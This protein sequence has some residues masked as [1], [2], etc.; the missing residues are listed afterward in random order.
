MHSQGRTFP[1]TPQNA[2]HTS[3]PAPDPDP[4]DQF[5]RLP[6]RRLGATHCSRAR[7]EDARNSAAACRRV[8]RGF[9]FS[10]S[11]AFTWRSHRRPDARLTTGK[12]GC[13]GTGAS[14]P[15]RLERFG[16]RCR[17]RRLSLV[18]RGRR[19]APPASCAASTIRHLRQVRVRDLTSVTGVPSASDAR[20]EPY[21]GASARTVIVAR[22]LSG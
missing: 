6:V 1:R 12:S 5:S 18:D 7:S 9:A 8:F 15:G 3:R 14:K 20:I 10:G 16:R 4:H 11:C 17:L 13:P 19:A 21:R 22:E 2:K